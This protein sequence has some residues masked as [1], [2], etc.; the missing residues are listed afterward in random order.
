MLIAR[1]LLPLIAYG[2]FRKQRS[3]ESEPTSNAVKS[4]A[5]AASSDAVVLWGV[6]Q[7]KIGADVTENAAF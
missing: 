3:E 4:H 5:G 6:K 7:A 1:R 2:P